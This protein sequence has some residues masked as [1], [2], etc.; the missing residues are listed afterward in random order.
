[1]S[2]RE[3]IASNIRTTIANISSPITIKKITRQPF[4]IDEL[5]QAQY[6]AVIVQSSLE[7]RE[8]VELGEGAK[9][10]IGNI[11][12]VIIGYVQGSESNIDTLRNELITTIET[13]LETDI[14][15]GGV[16]K[17]TQVVEVETDEGTLFPIGGIRMTINVMYDFQSGTP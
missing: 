8:D 15:R 1:M 10:R 5:A 17:D 2:V 14:T 4:N 13:A 12:F 7:T 16:A 11:E 3:D 6:P 9:T